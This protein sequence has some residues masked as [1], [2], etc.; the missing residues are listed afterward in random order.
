M[1]IWS[2]ALFLLKD[3]SRLENLGQ[4]AAYWH[5]H[6][7]S[8]NEPGFGHIFYIF[9]TCILHENKLSLPKITIYYIGLLF[10]I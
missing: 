2:D 8:Q 6:W 1:L 3:Q 7:S 9:Q 4:K 10:G 5:T